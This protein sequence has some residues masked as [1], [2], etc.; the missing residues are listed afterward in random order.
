M[1][2]LWHLVSVVY[3]W[4]HQH[5]SPEGWSALGTWATAAVAAVA[6]V[7]ALRQVREV[8]I[9][10]ERQAQPNVVAYIET[11]PEVWH[12][13]DLVVKNFGQTPAYHIKFYLNSPLPVVPYV[14]GATGKQVTEVAVPDEI[15]VLA[16]GQEW[17]TIW[18]SPRRR[19]QL[20][21]KA[22]RQK[23]DVPEFKTRFT[24]ILTFQDRPAKR[25][26]HYRNPIMLDWNAFYNT[27]AFA[28]DKPEKTI[29]EQIEAVADTLKWYQ[30]EHGGIWTYPVPADDER[31][32]R[33][34][35][36]AEAKA[37]QDL[38]KRA[39]HGGQGRH[40]TASGTSAE[41]NETP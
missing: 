12:Y 41:T 19:E 38:V 9:T 40:Q 11:N 17:R 23:K 33:E 10:R 14:S 31:R 4:L 37:A 29:A 26:N 6:A 30:Y 36:A 27:L 25:R 35:R 18:D 13:L 22:I 34:Q 16:P 20:R 5:V 8:R 1:S 2:K 21:D 15:A 3:H 24:G 7:F 32:Y 39:F 28:K